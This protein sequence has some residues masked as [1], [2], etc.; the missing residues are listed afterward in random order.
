MKR[1]IQLFIMVALIGFVSINAQEFEAAPYADSQQQAIAQRNTD[2][3][4]DHLFNI[5]LGSTGLES[6]VGILFINDQYWISQWNSNLLA[7]LDNTGTLIETFT[8][9]GV[10]GIR[11]ITTD[12]TSLYLGGAGSAI[13]E[14]DPVTRALLST[15]N[16][17]TAS[18]AAARMCTYDE[19]LDGGNGG[20]WIGNFESDIASVDMNGSELSVIPAATHGTVVYGG[21]ID[22]VSAGGPFLWIHDQSGV[23]P[24]QDFITQLNPSTGVPTGVVYDY[25]TDAP[26]GNTEALAGGL[27]ISTEVVVS[28]T[29]LVGICQ[30]A[31]NSQIFAI[32]LAN[33]ASINDNELANFSIYPNPTN[34]ENITIKTSLTGDKLIAIFDILGK[35]IIDTTITN[36]QLNIS[37]LTSGVYMVKVTQNENT[38]TKKLII[39]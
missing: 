24:N 11:S 1:K 10:T 37:T 19:T 36:D 4:F 12:G 16:I 3:L 8:I 28:T 17:T 27:S 14:V 33:T 34:S 15:I 23:S 35:N 6:M 5:D 39:R 25:T 22:N 29:A 2:A 38:A 7:V 32:E 30:C 18:T 26:G 9:A 31:P 21:V 13:Y 20:F